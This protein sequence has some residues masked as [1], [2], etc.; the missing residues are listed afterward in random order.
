MFMFTLTQIGD[1][2]IFDEHIF[3][4]WVGTK[5]T[6]Y[7][8]YVYIYMNGTW[9][10]LDHCHHGTK[11]S[12]LCERSQAVGIIRRSTGSETA[13]GSLV[14]VDGD[15]HSQKKVAIC[16]GLYDKSIYMGIELSTFPG[17]IF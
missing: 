12:T 9:F 14:K 17:G 8:L 15:R 11:G 3:F 5:N 4:R 1:D 13:D 10:F 6:S 16:K 2:P 7:I